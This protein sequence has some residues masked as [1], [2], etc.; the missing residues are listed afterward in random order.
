MPK[1][2]LYRFIVDGRAMNAVL[3]NATPQIYGEAT[4]NRLRSLVAVSTNFARKALSFWVPREGTALGDLA[5]GWALEPPKS[6]LEVGCWHDDAL[7]H[8]ATLAPAL[9]RD[10]DRPLPQAGT[11]LGGNSVQK[12]RFADHAMVVVRKEGAKGGDYLKED[13][14]RALFE[15]F[16]SRTVARGA[17]AGEEGAAVTYLANTLKGKT[18]YKRRELDANQQVEAKYAALTALIDELGTATTTAEAA[19]TLHRIAIVALVNTKSGLAS[20][21]CPD[22]FRTFHD[23]CTH[24]SASAFVAR[25]EVFGAGAPGRSASTFRTLVLT[26]LRAEGSRYANVV[27]EAGN[28]FSAAMRLHTIDQ[29]FKRTEAPVADELPWFSFQRALDADEHEE[30]E[31]RFPTLRF[32]NDNVRGKGTYARRYSTYGGANPVGIDSELKNLTVHEF[33]YEALASAKRTLERGKASLSAGERR[34]CRRDT[35]NLWSIFHQIVHIHYLLLSN[36]A[37]HGDMHMGNIKAIVVNTDGHEGVVVKAFDF[38]KAKY[39][40]GRNDFDLADL[41]YL[42]LRK[43]VSGYWET[44]KRHDRENGDIHRTDLSLVDRRDHKHYPIHQIL[45]AIALRNKHSKLLGNRVA[46]SN[47]FDRQCYFGSPADEIF[48]RN[49]INSFVESHGRAF[50]EHLSANA[51]SETRSATEREREDAALRASFAMFANTLVQHYY[52]TFAD[53][54]PD[55]VNAT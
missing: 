52:E 22:S 18:F 49:R 39:K 34:E 11:E 24:P 33:V 47:E 31:S 21:S 1:A 6:A 38:G 35:A 26:K 50:L 14:A 8:R 10:A 45:L 12:R 54:D 20:K 23:V 29:V 28:P 15:G 43:A 41:E 13:K 2:L 30:F 40:S 16:A 46:H 4:D 25:D 17:F 27:R 42:L 53:D 48:V 7:A 19:D 9:A 44:R 51:P 36:H 32:G 55:W 37:R 3:R 5:T